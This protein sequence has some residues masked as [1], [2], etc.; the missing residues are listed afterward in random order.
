MALYQYTALSKDGRRNM[1][2]INADSIDL[3]KERLRKEKILVTK[4]TP[5]KKKGDELRVPSSL[6][7]GFTRDLH[8]LLKASLPLYDSLM[9]LE[10]KY[11]RTKLH[12]IFLDLCDQ[13]KEGRHFSEAL[14]EY[15]KIFDPIYFSIVKASSHI[16]SDHTSNNPNDE[17]DNHH[18]EESHCIFFFHF[19]FLNLRLN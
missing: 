15:P 19:S 9:I 11:R 12:P 2:M 3:A 10:E 8:V 7:L 1:G 18:F 13:V 6:L 5:Y 17:N 16:V 4:L 14:K